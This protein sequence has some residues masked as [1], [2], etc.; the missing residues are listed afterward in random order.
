RLQFLF[1][2]DLSV[3]LQGGGTTAEKREGFLRSCV[4][5]GAG[6]CRRQERRDRGQAR[7][8]RD[9]RTLECRRT[10]NGR[11]VRTLEARAELLEFRGRPARRFF[12]NLLERVHR[13]GRA[14]ASG[15]V[16]G[17]KRGGNR[18]RSLVEQ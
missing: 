6:R 11:F 13:K 16:F 8:S 12:E 17:A 1:E 4:E 2:R 7:R 9:F 5:P 10:R 3:V 15:L 14:R 18:D